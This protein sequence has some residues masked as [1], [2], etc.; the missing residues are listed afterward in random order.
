M[1]RVESVEHELWVTQYMIQMMVSAARQG[2]CPPV[3]KLFPE[4]PQPLVRADKRDPEPVRDDGRLRRQPH[5]KQEKV[6]KLLER[7]LR[8]YT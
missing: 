1:R 6:V 5:H 8:A 4:H 2:G 7:Q 3:L